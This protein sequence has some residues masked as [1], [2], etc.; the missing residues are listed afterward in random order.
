MKYE[1][2]HLSFSETLGNTFLLYFDNFVALF[3]ISLVSYLPSIFFVVTANPNDVLNSTTWRIIYLFLNYIGAHTLCA[4]FTIGLISKKYLRQPLSIRGY[5]GDIIPLLLPIIGLS[6]IIL[7]MLAAPIFVLGFITGS[8]MHIL[9]YLIPVAWVFVTIVLS[10]QVLIVEQKGIITSLRRSAFLSR[11]NKWFIFAY[12]F[13]VGL[14]NFF[15]VNVVLMKIAFPV[16]RN[17]YAA[18]VTKLTLWYT[19]VYLVHILINPISACILVLVYFN[20][21][22]E[23][24]GFD[25]EHLV[26][27]FDSSEPEPEP[28][29]Q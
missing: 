2:K 27:Q 26:N 19:V 11:G 21:R 22:I 28:V 1:L 7:I 24:E 25:L 13:L 20:L 16:V 23:K 9:L 29:E 10:S 3:I 17:L 8:R 5:F 12:L 6:L 18:P 14:L 4:A 15:M